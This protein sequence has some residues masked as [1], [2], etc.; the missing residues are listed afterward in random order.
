[1]ASI[2][3]CRSDNLMHF[4]G[5]A[6][7]P[8]I[9][10]PQSALLI[11]ARGGLWSLVS[12]FRDTLYRFDGSGWNEAA[13]DPAE[14]ILTPSSRALAVAPGGQGWIVGTFGRRKHFDGTSITKMFPAADLL[15]LAGPDECDV[16]AVGFA[17]TVLRR[18]CG[19]NWATVDL[20]AAG[21]IP[22]ENVRS[23]ESGDLRNVVSAA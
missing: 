13:K 19:G 14:S 7:T 16:W 15:S 9:D 22:P 17:A 5:A 2:V 23:F 12:G 18:D 8:V 21:V 3:G 11:A 1:S 4:D 20:V 10:G 6:W